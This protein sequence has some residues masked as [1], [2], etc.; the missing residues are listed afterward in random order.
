MKTVYI[1]MSA[2][3]VTPGHVNIIQEAR[4]LGEV[5]IGLL[6]D[7]AVAGYQRLP[8][9]PYE[10]RKVVMENMVGV[11]KVVPQETLDHVP[12]LLKIK[13]D[14]VFH[15]ATGTPG[16]CERPASASSIHLSNG[17]GSLSSRSICP[18]SRPYRSTWRF[19]KSAP[20]RR[21]DWEC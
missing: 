3:L 4:A 6:T 21:C 8:Y 14:Y 19:G 9:M 10:Q 20:R 5:V 11:K 16:C 1:T 18:A 12:N 2:D 13:P 17:V 15:R 7:S